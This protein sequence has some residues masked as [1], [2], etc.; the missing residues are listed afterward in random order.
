MTFI[1]AIEALEKQIKDI[2]KLLDKYPDDLSLMEQLE[3]LI[4]WQEDV[5]TRLEEFATASKN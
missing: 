3:R 5:I 2:K 4:K 1:E